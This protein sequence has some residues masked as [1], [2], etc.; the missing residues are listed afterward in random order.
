MKNK[1][2]HLHLHTEYS[3]LDGVGKIDEYLDRALELKMDAVAITDHGNM[4][5]AI[6]FYKKARKRGIKPI[7]GMEAYISLGSMEDK[8]KTTYHLVL[9]AK[10]EVGYKNLMKLSSIGYLDGFYYKPRI[11]KTVLKKYSEGLIGLSACMQ[12]EIARGIRDEKTSEELGEVID[13]YI[14]IFGR[15]DFYIELQDNGIPEQYPMND[16]L[17]ELAKEYDLQV[18]G[19]NDVH[20]AHYGQ[21]GLQDVLI[22]IQTGSK[23]DD[24]K[25]MRIHTNELFM[26]S[27]DQLVEKLGRYEGALENTVKI[28]EKCNLEIEFGKFKFPEYLVYDG[29]DKRYPNGIEEK[30]VERVEYELGIINKMGYEEYFVV[31]W[32]F[33]DYAKKQKIPIGPGRGSAAGSM[34]AYTLGITELDPGK[35]ARTHRI[36]R[37]KIWQ[38]QGGSDNHLWDDEGESCHKRCGESI[39]YTFIQG[40]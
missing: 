21:H 1:F 2:V 9:L 19:T 14:D 13:S 28:A 11:D 22:C 10:N 20:Y 17:Y 26:K 4:F 33:I 29:L 15:E 24:E 30:V 3:L 34:V 27:R 39:K 16:K 31:V 6:E 8:E 18:V 40:G 37:E 25:R 36:C 32:D 35:T 5:G 23:I 38:R 7:L 12:G